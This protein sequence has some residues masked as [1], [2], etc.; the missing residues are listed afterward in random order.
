MLGDTDISPLAALLADPARARILLALGDRR[1]LAASV[2]ADEAGVAASTAS[3]HLSKL[4]GGGLLTVERHGR[5]RYFR[6]AGPEVGE[7]LELLSRLSGAAPIRSLREGTKANAVRFA[8]TCYDHL[9]GMLGTELMAALL[10]QG[11]LAGG[12][13]VF[14]PANAGR[15][16]LSAPG[17]DHDYRLT[18]AGVARM[19][20]FGIDFDAMPRRRPLVRYCVDWSEQRHHLAGA[21]GAALAERMFELRWIR[22]ADRSRAVHLTDAGRTGLRDTFG[23]ILGS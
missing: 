5:H 14:D 7:L 3:E 2:L 9:A 4:V 17:F 13:G 21:L 1:A 15:D 12:E 11:V 18:P 6:L 19:H 20:S 22:R 23:V 8:R 16:R 10:A